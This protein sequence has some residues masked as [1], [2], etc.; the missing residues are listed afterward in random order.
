ML[1][2]DTGGTRPV[3]PGLLAGNLPLRTSQRRR[4]ATSGGDFVWKE[5]G[6]IERRRDRET[7]GQRDG[8][9]E[10]RR[11]REMERRRED[12]VSPSLR[13]S[14]PP[15]LRLSVFLPIS[16]PRPPNASSFARSDRSDEWLFE[17]RLRWRGRCRQIFAGCGLPEG[18]NCS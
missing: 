3:T 12:I 17:N 16:T 18:T 10:R 6:E 8:E 9:T 11:D 4:P 2:F 15:S 14:V 7:E 1:A 5:N 13:L